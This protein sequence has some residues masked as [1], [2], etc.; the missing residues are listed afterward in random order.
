M[1]HRLD[2]LHK[3]IDDVLWYEKVGDLANIDKVYMYGPP[4]WKEKNP[5]AQG[6]GNP[7]KFWSYIFIPK[8]VDKSKKYPLV[9]LPH[10]GVHGDF[11]TYYCHIIR[12]LMAQEYIVVAP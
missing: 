3:K 8:S 4:K 9:V 6:A 7:V 5:T 1:E 11:T 2:V 12:E 10:G